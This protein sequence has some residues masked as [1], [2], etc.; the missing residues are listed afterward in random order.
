MSGDLA[1]QPSANN[2]R[3]FVCLQ[4]LIFIDRRYGSEAF[5]K[6]QY[7]AASRLTA[8]R[9]GRCRNF[10]KAAVREDRNESAVE[11]AVRAES[12]QWWRVRLL[13]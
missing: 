6:R 5:T 4:R 9:L 2:R 1:G 13:Q 11:S 7:W 10:V 3:R 8:V 12:G